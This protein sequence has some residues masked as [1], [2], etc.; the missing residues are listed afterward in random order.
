MSRKEILK[1][2]AA[3]EQLMATMARIRRF[4]VEH[5]NDPATNILIQQ[6]ETRKELLKTNYKTFQSYQLQLLTL[7][8]DSDKSEEFENDY[9]DILSEI[10]IRLTSYTNKNNSI[11]PEITEVK[12]G[13][14]VAPFSPVSNTKLPSIEIP[15]FDGKNFKEFRPFYEIFFAVIDKNSNLSDVEKLFYLRS[16]LR[17]EALALVNTLPIVN[18]SYIET[19]NI[20]KNRFDNETMLIN[21]HINSI[22]EI[23]SVQKGTP[24]EL[25]EFISIVK[26]QY[27]SLKNLQQPVDQWDMI[28]ICIL[29]KKLDT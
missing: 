11:I 9:F 3:I 6:L 20:L 10:N 5:E 1:I 26:Q 22:L 24:S 8:P 17:G 28:L 7:S 15:I 2:E 21:S 14:L 13:S 27:S 12:S 23:Q 4:L 18:S 29:N 19:L 25:R 16:Y